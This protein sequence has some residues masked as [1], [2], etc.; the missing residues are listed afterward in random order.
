MLRPCTF[1]MLAGAAWACANSRGG[2]KPPTLHQD[3]SAS[4]RQFYVPAAES[5]APLDARLTVILK[6]REHAFPVVIGLRRV[7]LPSDVEVLAGGVAMTWFH[8]RSIRSLNL[9]QITEVGAQLKLDVLE[10]DHRDPSTEHVI[11]FRWSQ[12]PQTFD[13]HS[14]MAVHMTLEPV[15]Q[16]SEPK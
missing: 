5:D 3:A 1:L 7:S 14:E 11:A 13:L 4:A 8:S 6:R 9:T 15:V 16:A 12:L 10:D 2:P